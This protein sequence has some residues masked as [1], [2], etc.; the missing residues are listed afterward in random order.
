MKIIA[1]IEDETFV[2]SVTKKEIEQFLNLYYNKMGKLKV[3]DEVDLGQ[4]YKF[5]QEAIDAM[6]KTDAFLSANKSVME[7][8]FKGI[9][10]VS[11]EK[12]CPE[13]SHDS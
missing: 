10:I 4:G 9:S 1:H 11:L 6:K 8:I 7:A 13:E 2:C 3:G 12:N 5:H